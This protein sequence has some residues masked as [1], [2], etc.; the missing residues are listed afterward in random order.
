MNRGSQRL[1]LVGDAW[2]GSNTGFC[3]P[4]RVATAGL[5]SSS[6]QMASRAT[7][8]R[9]RTVH[10]HPRYH[11]GEP[12]RLKKRLYLILEQPGPSDR[13]ARAWNL[14][15]MGA[16]AISTLAVIA[17]TVETIDRQYQPILQTI[18]VASLGLFGAEY[19][20]RLWVI[21]CSPRYGHP[22]FGRL[23]F[24]ITP[25]ALIDLLAIAPALVAT[26]VDLRFLRVARLARVLRVLKLARYSQSMGLI[27]RVVRRKREELLIALGL[28]SILL[29]MASALMYFAE[30]AAQPKAFSSIPAA[31]WWAVVT[32]TTLGYG[33]V[34][35][36][37]VAGRFLAGITALLGI[38]AFAL[39]TSILGAGF[40]A[41]LE[42]PAKRE[43]C[44]SCG[45][46]L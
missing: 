26:R 10:E 46:Q 23:R 30:H 40:L 41:E 8:P 12:L 31:M 4:R 17:E 6:V 25:L 39:P 11:P 9:H 42:G 33:D 44:P 21:T 32:M 28:F 34:Y 22:L 14:A 5:W 19:L 1:L 15:I 7:P 16:I 2:I 20:L 27:A 3:H 29:V 38:A 45:A 43:K 36:V 37:T 13:L 35:P 24:A 18:E